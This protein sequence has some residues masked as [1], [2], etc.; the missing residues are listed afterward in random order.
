[1]TETQKH[2]KLITIHEAA[3]TGLIPENT[4]RRLCKSNK[5]PCLHIGNRTFINLDV[6]ISF[7]SD[8]QNY[9]NGGKANE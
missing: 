7:L 5:V 3:Q 9:L 2:V 6:L 1:M 4:L 8:P